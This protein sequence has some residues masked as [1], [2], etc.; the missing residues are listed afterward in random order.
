MS[1]LSHLG[2]HYDIIS[3]K[4]PNTCILAFGIPET[5][6]GTLSKKEQ[7]V[8]ELICIGLQPSCVVIFH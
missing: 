4:K 5:S 2:R 6:V 8:N 1:V 3:E 7:P